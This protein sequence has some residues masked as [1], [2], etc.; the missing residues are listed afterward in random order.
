[1]VAW[2]CVIGFSLLTIGALSGLG[3][4]RRRGLMARIRDLVFSAIVLSLGALCLGLTVALRAFEAFADSV[5]VS[6]VRC[7]WVGPKAFHL[8]YV[9]FRKGKPQEPKTFR[10]RGD[11]WS[12]S[13]GV[14]K[15][16][17]WLT[18]L[19]LPSYHRPTRISGR[20]AQTAEETQGPPAAFN[21]DGELDRIWWLF[22]RLD[23]FLPFVDAT[24]GSS[25][26]T[27]VNP[28]LLFE[29]HVTPSGYLIQHKRPGQRSHIE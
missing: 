21:L 15:W 5:K 24:Y 12:V 13:G 1:M 18:A 9:P 10:L 8:T 26:F 27:Y 25:A 11:Q 14:V 22:Y 23:P 17:P 6:E 28:A 20:Y 3:A 2:L 4:L 29:V 7:A 16:H 19:G